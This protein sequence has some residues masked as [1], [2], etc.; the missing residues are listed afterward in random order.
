MDMN[1]VSEFLRQLIQDHH[2]QV[3]IAQKMLLYYA[4]K[5]K[6]HHRVCFYP[7]E[8]YYNLLSRIFFRRGCTRLTIRSLS[9]RSNF[10]SLIAKTSK[11]L[12]ARK[13][14][15]SYM[16]LVRLFTLSKT[17]FETSNFRSNL[18]K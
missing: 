16:C 9:T 13:T 5:N 8:Q 10:D 2:F 15:N 7:C 14:F 6:L 3:D 1:L 12:F 18:I 4:G 17:I 11:G